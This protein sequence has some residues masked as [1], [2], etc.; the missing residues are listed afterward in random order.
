MTEITLPNGTVLQKVE[1]G[2][3]VKSDAP[4]VKT[5]PKLQE[6]DVKNVM[7]ALRELGPL[8][9]FQIADALGERDAYINASIARLMANKAIVST[10]NGTTA[11]YAIPASA[12]ADAE[13]PTEVPADGQAA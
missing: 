11:V 12:P 2:T 4:K 7:V 10:R 6:F 13:T 3:R 5:P 1:R 9:K 8:T